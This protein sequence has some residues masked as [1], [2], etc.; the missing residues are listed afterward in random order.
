MRMNENLTFTLIMPGTKGQKWFYAFLYNSWNNFQNSKSYALNR[1]K[2][3]Y[4]N[5]CHTYIHIYIV[6]LL[7]LRSQ[8]SLLEISTD[9]NMFCF[10]SQHWHKLSCV[11]VVNPQLTKIMVSKGQCNQN[12]YCTLLVMIYVYFFSMIASKNDLHHIMP[13]VFTKLKHTHILIWLIKLFS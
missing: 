8:H 7:S 6:C 11:M 13:S 4:Y 5:E 1:C 12:K 9:N 10:I 3:T 2:H